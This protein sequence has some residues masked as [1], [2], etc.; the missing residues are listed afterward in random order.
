MISLDSLEMRVGLGQFRELS[1]ER[2]QFIK[3]C[4]VDDFQ[5]NTPKMPGSQR[6]EYENLA[7]LVHQASQYDLRLMALEN[8]PNT[9]W[10]QIMLGLPG[11]A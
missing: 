11:R 2:L 4:G 6:W 10:D 7:Q 8:V 9:F 1:E 5:L 3:Q